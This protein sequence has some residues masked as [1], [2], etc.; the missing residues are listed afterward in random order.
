MPLEN[1]FL[2]Q[3]ERRKLLQDAHMLSKISDPPLPPIML[4]RESLIAKLHEIIGPP[5]YPAG[6]RT[7]HCKLV[8]LCTPAGYGKTTALADYAS[9]T[10]LPCCW[11]F[12]E[13]TDGDRVSFLTVLLASIRLRFPQFGAGL[14]ALLESAIAA[15][16]EHPDNWQYFEPVLDALVASIET[17]ISVRFVLLLCNYHEVNASESINH[18]VN[19]LLQKLPPQCVITY[20]EPL[21]ASIGSSQSTCSPRNGWPG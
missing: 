8:L 13:Q 14:D 9:S 15:N 2:Y 21:S 3:L 1:V 17:E 12:L 5:W 19:R 20:R 6:I 16:T 4:H 10:Q 18:L 11:F 7:A